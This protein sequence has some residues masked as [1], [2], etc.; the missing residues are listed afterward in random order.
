MKIRQFFGSKGG[1]GSFKQT[2]DN[3]RSEDTFEGVLGLGL[4][5]F[6]GLTRG[7]KVVKVD[8]TAVE[9]ETGELNFKDFIVNVGDGDPLK[10]PQKVPLRLGA[11]ASPLPVNLAVTNPAPGTTPGPWVTKTLTNTGAAFIDL[12]LI[13]SQLYRQ[14]KD[15][16]FDETASL[17]VQLKPVGSTTWINPNLSSGSSTA[18]NQ[19]GYDASYD[20]GVYGKVYLPRSYFNSM[21]TDYASYSPHFKVTGKTTGPS[22]YELRIAVPR[23]GNYTSTAWDVRVR[24]IER[25]TYDNGSETDNIQEKRTIQW[26]SV[27][28]VYPNELGTAEGWRGVAWM[29][30]YGKASNQLTGVPSVTA[31][32]DTKIVAVPT[33]TIFNPA[34]RQYTPGIWDGSW[35]Y[36]Y[37]NDPAW[38]IA[39]LISDSIGGISAL[40]PGSYLNKWDALEAS[41][42][43]SQLV[44][45][46][47]GGQ[48]P[49]FSMNIALNDKQKADDL[50]RYMAGA[51]GGLAWDS[52]NGEWRLKIDKP[53]A[54]VD[55]FTLETIEGDFEYS[56]TDVDTR[57]NDITGKFLNADMDYRED[58]VRLFDSDA[59]AR[60]GRKP[61][62]VALVGCTNRQEALRRVMLRLRSATRETRLV[63]F[64]TNRRGRNLVPLDTILVADGGLG[65]SAQRTTGRVISVAPD[66]MSLT[67]RDTVRLEV[68]VAYALKFSVRNPNYNVNP[69]TQP[70]D[71]DWRKP[72]IVQSINVTNTSGQRGDVTTIY[73]ASALPANVAEYLPVALEATALPTLPKAYR[74]LTID[75]VDD[76][77]RI[78]VS[79]IEIDTGKWA[80][81]DAVS[82]VD[83]VYSAMSGPPD[84]P[85][86]AGASLLTL[87]TSP[88][89][90]GSN[91]TLTANWVRPNDPRVTG[92]RV[93]YRVNNGAWI[94][95]VANTQLGDFEL[96]NPPNGLYEF[97]ICSIGRNGELS[98]PLTGSMQVARQIID[99]G[100]ITYDDGTPIEEL[101]PAEGGATDGA[102]TGVNLW[103]GAGSAVLTDGT[104]VTSLGTAAA[105]AGQGALATKNTVNLASEVTGALGTANAAAGLVNTN[106]S[107][108]ANG[109]LSG[110]GGG[111]V[112]YAGVGGKAL[113][114]KDTLTFGDAEFREAGSTVATVA[115]F[116][117]SLGTA[118][119]ITG[120]GTFATKSTLAN[121]DIG[122]AVITLDKVVQ[123]SGNLIA[124]GEFSTGDFR[125]WRQWAGVASQAIV[126][127]T[128]AGVPANAPSRNVLRMAY[129]GTATDVG[130]FAATKAYSD[131]GADNDGFTV[132]PGERYRVRLNAA[133][134]ADYAAAA[135]RVRA[136]V[137]KSD[138]TWTTYADC[139][140]VTPA[141]LTTSFADYLG[142]FV[143]PAGAQRCWLYLLSDDQT[144]GTVF[145]SELWADRVSGQ[146]DLTSNAVRLG[147][148]IVRADG[149][150]SVN[151]A[152]VVTA[153]GT[154]ASITGQGPGATAPA[155]QVMN[156]RDDTNSGFVA[157][158]EGGVLNVNNSSQVGAIKIALPLGWTNTMVRFQVEVFNYVTGDIG[159]YQISGYTYSGTGAG[160]YWVNHAATYIG[161]RSR[162]LTVRF[163]SDGTK[164]CVWIG[165]PDTVWQ[166][167][168]AHVV[169]VHT[170]FSWS[171]QSANWRTGWAMSL[172]AAAATN[173]GGDPGGLRVITAPRAGDAVF[174]EGIQ[175]TAG[176]TVATL[177]NFKTGLGTAAAIT[178]QGALATLSAATWGSHISGRPAELTDG[179][180]TVALRA[181][182]SMQG[183]LYTGSG[184]TTLTS[185]LEAGLRG[186][187]L[188]VDPDFSRGVN[189]LSLYGGA[190]A[191]SMAVVDDLTAPNGSGKIV[192]VSY[193][194]SG[195]A[196][197]AYGGFSFLLYDAGPSGLSRPGYY[198]RGT[199]LLYVLRAKIPVGRTLNFTTN[200]TGD[201]ITAAWLTSQVGT[202][203]Y[204]TYIYRRT[205]GTTGS[206]QSTGYFYVNGGADTAF[207]WDVAYADVR[208]LGTADLPQL[209]RLITG[210]GAITTD[211]MLITGQGTAAAITG[212]GSL[213]TQNSIGFGSGQLTGLPAAIQPAN[214]TGGS[215]RSEW[216]YDTASGVLIRDRWPQ[217][218]GANI[219]ENRVASAITGQ[220]SLATKNTADWSADVSGRPPIMSAEAITA[221]EFF[222]DPSV[223][224]M[225]VPSFVNTGSDGFT[226]R[227]TA[228]NSGYVY[229]RFDNATVVDPTATYEAYWD[230]LEEGSGSPQAKFY[231][232]I[233]AWDSSGNIIAG[234]GSYWFYPAADV[235]VDARGVWR[236]YTAQFGAGTTK[237]FPTNAARFSVGFLSNYN[238]SASA[239][240]VRRMWA[241]RIEMPA[242]IGGSLS[243]W[244]FADRKVVRHR[245]QGG[246]GQHLAR[247]AEA[248]R[249]PQSLSARPFAQ[250]PSRGRIMLALDSG[251]PSSYTQFDAAWFYTWAS[252]GELQI[253]ENGTLVVV[254]TGYTNPN[255]IT[256]RID[257]DGLYFRYYVNGVLARSSYAGANRTFRAF[258]DSYDT[259]DVG[260]SDF[261]HEAGR[262]VS[263]I[264]ENTY[265]PDGNTLNSAALVTV[266]GT[267]AAIT[268][269]GSLATKSAVNLASTEVINKSLANLDST[270]N[271]K[272]SGIATGA[273]NDSVTDNRNDN[274][275]PSWY[276][277]NFPRRVV[278][279]FKATT[280]LGLTGGTYGALQTFVDYSD[281]SG[282]SVKQRFTHGSGALSGQVWMRVGASNDASWGSWVRDYSGFNKPAF[283]DDLVETVGGTAATLANF[284]TGLG[285]AAAITGQGALATKS[286][287]AGSDIGSAVVSFDKLTSTAAR[288][289]TNVVRADGSTSVTDALAITSLGTAASI[290]GQGALATKNT[291]TWST[292]VTGSG[293]P[294]DNADVTALAQVSIALTTDQ[295]IPATYNG[296]V[297]TEDLANIIWAP[298]VSK[299]GS[300]IKTAN[301]VSY[302]LANASGGTFAVDNTNGSSTKG[303]VTISAMSSNIAQVELTITVD[304]VVQP[305]LL[306]K[307]TKNLGAP[308]PSGG[309]TPKTVTWGAGEFATLNTTS[310]TPVVTALK[311]VALASGESL[312][313]TAPLTYNVAGTNTPPLNRTM[314][315][316]WQYSVAG[317][318]SWN[319]F[320]S[321]ITGSTASCADFANEINAVPGTVA[322]TQTKSG[323]GA[324]NYD[325]RL[326]AVCSATGRNMSTSGTATVEAKV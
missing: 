109:A 181:D 35:A 138:G 73:L 54:P 133:K 309:S 273:T 244:T 263:I 207:D 188:G 119:A 256:L 201:G 137:Y 110:A 274:Q 186:K 136:Y 206:F 249:G 245:N 259:D 80:A 130:L 284:K 3:L 293:K 41:K 162:A 118:A 208:E 166:Y 127:N 228:N 176:G 11:G 175:E 214:M 66:R 62:A 157:K 267:A 223:W 39:D 131:A 154:A 60:N 174:G 87:F 306:L 88:A 185:L 178:S 239:M 192:R 53:E 171:W 322:V 229:S 70:T 122:T 271:T 64:V 159:T 106:I 262:G 205:I 18:Y 281:S 292:D 187:S 48:H 22:I 226:F 82:K 168:K 261:R 167:P 231:T 220:G 264:G 96:V 172:D 215:I 81:S 190:G 156:F 105:I 100:D 129:T 15:G 141:S 120:Q 233:I 278:N 179:R 265:R 325:V 126:V 36:A 47:D 63:N 7:L 111:Q 251:N 247:S 52:G 294:Q 14:T 104:V 269:Q 296:T 30:L 148:N 227:T 37:T 95:A 276:R 27:A 314:T 257:Y 90:Q 182:G 155:A 85:S 72:L 78:R 272:L 51:V 116:K 2:P 61:S 108:A 238:N 43:F 275:L 204:E 125:G 117:T 323:L 197:P 198:A 221:D 158:P 242:L 299:G 147:T 34:T 283:G 59:I 189:P 297:T 32:F 219:T 132:L 295:T 291:A 161:P 50:V 134:S 74:V 315:F 40:A 102:Q 165:E 241:R 153:Q 103:N 195:T 191:V 93:R 282:G 31:E 279:E 142:T 42:W 184:K 38:C 202:G 10:F 49:R 248:I 145:V 67:V 289:G 286:T 253:Y 9:N 270:A 318:N 139:I 260:W 199:T 140:D 13:V 91:V 76:N 83:T 290:T 86:A 150:T 128:T 143:A 319:D 89:A 324:G 303:N 312:Y 287:I 320:A 304:S 97:E 246:W 57:H 71:A 144:A 16:I 240:Q 224:W 69:T 21:G 211:A 163:G 94:L 200:P 217:E 310:Y 222:R 19:D 107:I 232:A 216:L 28:A 255:D 317:A 1:G 99:A 177:A 5:P 29:Q 169:N 280:A 151:E 92:S 307:V 79:A 55:V 236:R 203:N 212:Q 170:A 114:L 234:D 225:S 298:A 300:S 46:G 33:G 316:K 210:A 305:K 101:Q 254:F 308:P 243:G 164:A 326:V 321:P 56:H 218:A 113:G 75:P 183:D 26:E 68:G 285:T 266:E 44:S 258:V 288:F 124:N 311:T 115:N 23:T 112:T 213:A 313:G 77:E 235:T 209:A 194:G 6:K 24:L 250:D 160:G 173:T 123:A 8:G 152:L 277:T 58:S 252:L 25:D 193:N 149:S 146:N 196:S 180:I 4:G 98:T 12:R 237:P 302:S 230:V 45:D 135:L 65:N 20:D 301:N 17:E 121:S 268:G 84:A